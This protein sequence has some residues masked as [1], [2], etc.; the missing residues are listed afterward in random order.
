MSLTNSF[1]KSEYVL[2]KD[3][4]HPGLVDYIEDT[5]LTRKE[6]L[7][8]YDGCVRLRPVFDEIAVKYDVIITP[9][10]PDEAPEGFKTGDG[11]WPSH[12]LK[13]DTDQA[14]LELV[15]LP[16]VVY[17]PRSGRKRARFC[18]KDWAATWIE[19]NRSTLYG[20]KFTAC[21]NEYRRFVRK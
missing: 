15:I 5:K 18:W 16:Y 12:P 21:C 3:K 20:P 9:T 4:L 6:I 17:P 13:A 7:E 14:D 11:V 10:A 1:L 19:F 2:A 8:A